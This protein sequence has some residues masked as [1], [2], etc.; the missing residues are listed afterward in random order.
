MNKRRRFLCRL[1]WHDWR[2]HLQLRPS[3]L[4][5]CIKCGARSYD[6][7]WFPDRFEWF[8]YRPLTDLDYCEMRYREIR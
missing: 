5:R 4:C 2:Q 3:I 1:G 8:S 6:V 7:S